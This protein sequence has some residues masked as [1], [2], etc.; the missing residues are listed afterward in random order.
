MKSRENEGMSHPQKRFLIS[1][2][3]SVMHIKQ[4]GP[5]KTKK[6]ILRFRFE[7]HIYTGS[8]FRFKKDETISVN[9]RETRF[10]GIPLPI[11]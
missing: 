5:W 9:A 3:L 8:K 10:R 2:A 6:V 7:F 11:I 4:S 1:N